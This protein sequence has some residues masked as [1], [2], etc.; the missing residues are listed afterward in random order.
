M[1]AVTLTSTM[2]MGAL[3]GCTEKDVTTA[4][5]AVVDRP[6]TWIADRTITVQAYV[7]DIGYSIPDDMSQTPVM[8]EIKRLTGIDLKIQYTP[9]DSD[10]DVLAS[11]LASGTIPDVVVTYLDDSSRPEFTLLLKGAKEGLFADVSSYM[12]DSEVYSKYYEEDYLPNDAYNNITFREDINGAAYIMQLSIDAVDKSLEYNPQ[13][14]YVG[15]LYIQKSIVEALGIDPGKIKTQ[16]QFY[17]LLV[18]IKNGGFTDDHGQ[19]VYPLGPKYWGGSTDTI[20][21]IVPEYD[22]GVS[23]GY[24]MDQEGNIKHEVETDYVYKKVDFV[25]KLV[26]EKLINPEFF[27]MDSTRAAEISETHNSAIIGDVHNYTEMIYQTGDWVPLGPINNYTGRVEEPV[28]GKSGY[29]AWAISS[30]AE[31]PEEIFAFFDFLSTKQGKMLGNYGVEGVHYDLVDGKPVLKEEVLTHINDGDSKW[32][33]NNVGASFGGSGVVFWEFIMT[34]INWLE[35]CGESRPGAGSSS[36]FEGA[37]QI[38]TDY[39]VEKVLVPGLKATA[40]LS[41]EPLQQVKA[42]MSLLNYN[43]MLV[44]AIYAPN[45]KEAKTIIE[46]FR[47]QLEKA[48]LE[49][50]RTYLEEVYEKDNESINFY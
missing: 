15:G 3:T 20:K 47:K 42:Q 30:E 34:D 18:A 1:M 4:P 19:P 21:Y 39:P 9:G 45:D 17:D 44:Q 5:V 46:S 24:N 49:E 43:E 11:H 48:G 32:L 7:D 6:D 37:I 36:G 33:I 8:Q 38:A 12:K 23:D 10:S 25:R 31:N 26:A 41:V 22:W 16:E 27:T 14:E 2:L 13:E 40:Y 50:F 35:E 28:V 29:G